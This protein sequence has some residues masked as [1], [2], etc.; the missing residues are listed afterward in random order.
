MG[1]DHLHYGTRMIVRRLQLVRNQRR[2]KKS[3]R[4]VKG[5]R[6]GKQQKLRR[7][8]RRLLVN[9]PG[10][11]IR[12]TKKSHLRRSQRPLMIKVQRMIRRHLNLPMLVS[13]LKVK[14]LNLRNK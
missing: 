7:N 9:V 14:L 11:R 10:R 3:P 1:G 12:K 6:K 5:R 4:K 13:T 8:R 2:K